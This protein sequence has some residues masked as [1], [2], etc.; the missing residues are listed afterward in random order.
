[1]KT[2][3]PEIT[4][5]L[6]LELPGL[7]HV[8]SPG[9]LAAL[10]RTHIQVKRENTEPGSGEP[11]V[12]AGMQP[13][14]APCAAPAPSPGLLFICNPS[15]TLADHTHPPVPV[16]PHSGLCSSQLAWMQPPPHRRIRYSKARVG[17][18]A[19]PASPSPARVARF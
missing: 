2:G 13:A 8:G 4:G 6:F 1:M 16:W 14:H 15:P 9:P 3:P 7:R 5:L 17:I 10:T 11:T 19:A 12:S 18:P